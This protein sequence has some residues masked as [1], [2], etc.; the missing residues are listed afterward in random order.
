MF[1][2]LNQRSTF[3]IFLLLMLTAMVILSSASL[4]LAEGETKPVT[5]VS[6]VD[7]SQLLND[8][9]PGIYLVRFEE[10]PLARYR[11]GESNLAPTNPRHAAPTGLTPTMPTA[12]HTANS[13][14]TGAANTLATWPSESAVR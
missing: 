12:A 7:T 10:A 2:K 9:E 3:G 11:G 13:W 6:A 4:S 5:A 14:P 8:T 1:K